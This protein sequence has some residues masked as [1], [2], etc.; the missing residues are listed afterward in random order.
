MKRCGLLFLI[1]ALVL[2][3]LGTMLV[4]SPQVR[5]QNDNNQGNQSNDDESKIKQ[6]LAIAPVPLNLEGKNRALVELGCYIV[7]AQVECYW[8]HGRNAAVEFTP[9]GNPYRVTPPFSGTKTVNSSHY[10][11]G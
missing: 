11:A 7:N 9:K 8:C 1:A 6:G 2:L 4:R 10:L 3:C 5:A